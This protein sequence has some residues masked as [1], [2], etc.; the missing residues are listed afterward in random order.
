MNKHWYIKT[1]KHDINIW[2]SCSKNNWCG[3][4]IEHDKHEFRIHLG[5]LHF[6]FTIYGHETV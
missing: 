4:G 1:K 3:F 6:D 2:L 5:K